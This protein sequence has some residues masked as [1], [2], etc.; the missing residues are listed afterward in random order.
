M[1][2]YLPINKGDRLTNDRAEQ[3]VRAL[4]QT[5][6]F[7]D[8]QVDREGDIMVIKVNERPSIAKMTLRGNKD[9]KEDDLRKGLKEIGLAE[10]E[11]FDRLSLDRVQKELIRQYYNR[12]KYNVSV[13]PHVTNLDRN[14]VPSISRSAK[15]RSPRSRKST[16]SATRR[17]PT[18][19]SARFRVEY[20]ELAF[21]VFQG[22]P[23]LAR[24]A[25]R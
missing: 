2:T 25:V 10:G 8:V 5:K 20:A 11:T 1:F 24:E 16:S 15:A 17:S 18:R 9:L 14:R 21:L 19:K 13:D 22:R 6:F 3:A 4:Y 23:V 7:S 12:G